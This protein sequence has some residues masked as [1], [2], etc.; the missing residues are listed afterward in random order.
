MK[1]IYRNII[2]GLL[3]FLGYW[4]ISFGTIRLFANN[5]FYFRNSFDIF[6]QNWMFWVFL[7]EIVLFT[8][9]FLIAFRYKKRLVRFT[10]SLG[11]STAITLFSIIFVDDLS[12]DIVLSINRK[13]D[14]RLNE[15][16]FIIDY[17]SVNSKDLSFKDTS[18]DSIYETFYDFDKIDLKKIKSKD[19]ITLIV[20]KGYFGIEHFEIKDKRILK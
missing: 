5:D 3:I 15:K 8:F 7:I 6:F 19:T 10:M 2:I 13:Y 16:D 18:N 9:I 17:F 4:N 1:K 14:K 20:G 12:K 11:F